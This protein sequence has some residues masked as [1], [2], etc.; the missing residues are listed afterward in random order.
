MLKN[1]LHFCILFFLSLTQFIQSQDHE[2]RY[3]YFD[4]TYYA[5]R[6]EL[7]DSTDIIYGE[8]NLTLSFLQKADTLILDLAN[9]NSGGKG[10][11]IDAIKDEN[12]SVK[13]IHSCNKIKI[14]VAEIPEQSFKTYT[15]RYHGIPEDGLIIS[16]NKFGDR[17]FFGDNWPNR[18]HKWLPC[19]DHPADKARLK[20]TVVAPSRYQVVANGV[21]TKET[22]SNGYITSSWE[23][24]VPLSTK[25]M[26]I[27]VAKFAKQDLA[28]VSGIPVSTWVY[29]QN[30]T[31]GFNDYA[32]A[33]KPMVYFSNLIAPFPFA[34]LANVQSTTLYGGME[35]ASCIFYS[36]NSVNGKGRAERL[37]AH[38][39]AHQWFGDAVSEK[40]WYHIWLSEG[41]A[42]YLTGM[43]IEQNY[44]RAAFINH[45][46]REKQEVFNFEKLIPGPIID[47]TLSVSPDL[48]SPNTYQKAS[49]MLHMLR[50]ELGDSLFTS[51]LKTFY[52][53]YQNKNAMTDD[54]KTVVEE[55][56]GR[57][58]DGFFEQWLYKSGHPVLDIAWVYDG[59]S[60]VLTIKQIQKNTIYQFPL[61]L[62]IIN[63]NSVSS[64]VKVEIT[65]A[66]HTYTL[67]YPNSPIE[68]IPDPGNWLLMESI[69]NGNDSPANK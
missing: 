61:E 12:G 2:S 11:L 5:F 55:L 3:K 4:V 26:V 35:N 20:F 44:G 51:C 23:S 66:E 25:L 59:H 22:V 46:N 49:W 54:F 58:F 56:S 52:K 47:T 50:K 63:K 34:K 24:T 68:L 60:L 64:Q 39:I 65:S 42:T 17:T 6:I 19:I 53:E 29:P 10:M 9:L 31:E 43:Y 16:K 69:V 21:C 15:I 30:Q 62:K 48:L 13:I 33:I 28:S 40:D 45:I 32:A 67:N 7:N 41:F 37:M 1:K 27:G 18:A 38:E 8:A 14:P 57:D 36:E